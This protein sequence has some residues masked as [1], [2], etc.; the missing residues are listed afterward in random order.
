MWILRARHNDY[1]E[2][3]V[4][5]VGR[6]TTKLRHVKKKPDDLLKKFWE[7][8]NVNV[9]C[10]DV[11]IVYRARLCAVHEKFSRLTKLN[12]LLYQRLCTSRRIE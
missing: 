11:R 3:S 9:C 7:F 5:K 4:A 12:F 8:F 6:H 2:S 1:F 10:N